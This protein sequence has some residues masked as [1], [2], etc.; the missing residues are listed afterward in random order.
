MMKHR[1]LIIILLVSPCDNI[2]GQDLPDAYVG[3]KSFAQSQ[4]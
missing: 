1:G 3:G 2:L 4:F